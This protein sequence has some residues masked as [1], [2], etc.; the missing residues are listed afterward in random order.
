MEISSRVNATIPMPFRGRSIFPAAS[1]ALAIEHGCSPY[2]TQGAHD[3]LESADPIPRCTA[4]RSTHRGPISSENIRRARMPAVSGPKHRAS[5]FRGRL[6]TEASSSN[7]QLILSS[8]RL[9]EYEGGGEET[10][11]T[12]GLAELKQDMYVEIQSTDASERGI[13]GGGGSG[14]RS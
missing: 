1:S 2:A 11:S 14:P 13:K 4:K 6:S 7:S 10:R 8:G 3:C 5:A 12:N 9:V